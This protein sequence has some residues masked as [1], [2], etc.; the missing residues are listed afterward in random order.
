[1][2]LKTDFKN[3]KFA[4]K[5]KYTLT[6]ND[7]GTISL[8]DV[9]EYETVGDIYGATEVNASNTAINQN[10]DDI[11]QIRDEDLV[12]IRGVT[13][14]TLPVSGWS[15]SAPYTQTV[16]LPGIKSTDNPIPLYRYPS[17]LTE[18]NKNLID[19]STNMITS[20]KTNNG[21][22]TV[23]CKFRKPVAEIIIGLKGVEL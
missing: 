17:N 8:D 9:T 4:G 10:T 13:E 14:I 19:R 3:D 23:T 22:V 15:S 18:A 16:S 5:R 20:I 6:E 11:A 12:Q 1:M 7:D 21:S 2:S